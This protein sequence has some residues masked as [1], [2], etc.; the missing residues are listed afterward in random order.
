M[1]ATNPTKENEMA[2]D[3]YEMMFGEEAPEWTA[4]DEAA[5][6]AYEAKVE[7]GKATAEAEMNAANEAF[8]AELEAEFGDDVY[9]DK[10]IHGEG[11]Y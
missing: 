2:V 3:F 6:E 9:V 7:A 11:L 4:E 1:S 8:Y 5:A 10:G